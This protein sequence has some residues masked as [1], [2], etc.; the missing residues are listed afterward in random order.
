MLSNLVE[1]KEA[2]LF[3][4][5]TAILLLAALAGGE[6][7]SRESSMKVVDKLVAQ[8]NILTKEVSVKKTWEGKIGWNISTQIQDNISECPSSFGSFEKTFTSSNTL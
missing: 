2:L 4:A 1:E 5:S 8:F 7:T 6:E 3:V